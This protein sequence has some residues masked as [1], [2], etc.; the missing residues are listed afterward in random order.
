MFIYLFLILSAVCLL[1]APME[2][3]TP[4]TSSSANS[5]CYDC[6]LYNKKVILFYVSSVIEHSKQVKA[7][8]FC[9]QLHIFEDARVSVQHSFKPAH[10]NLNNLLPR[11]Q[12]SAKTAI[13][14]SLSCWH[15]LSAPSRDFDRPKLPT[16]E[17]GPKASQPL[18]D[19]SPGRSL[20]MRLSRQRLLLK[21]HQSGNFRATYSAS[22]EF[23]HGRTWV[24]H[25]CKKKKNEYSK[26]KLGAV[27]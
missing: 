20:S 21:Q 26:K 8:Q 3:G 10:H 18:G 14:C 16:D 24:S 11:L 17:S 13:I 27:E 22:I 9:V 25:N 19:I 15:F 12:S 2:A 1:L 23:R 5:S 6:I 4:S 7:M